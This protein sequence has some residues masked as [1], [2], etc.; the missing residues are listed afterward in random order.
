[1]AATTPHQTTA[2]EVSHAR[3]GKRSQGVATALA[4]FRELSVF[5][6]TRK[7]LANALGWDEKTVDRWARGDVSRVRRSGTNRVRGLLMLCTE[8]R[9]YM[10]RACDVGAWVL[11]RLPDWDGATPAA[12]VQER[13][14]RGVL[15]LSKRIVES[16]PRQE[17]KPL[18]E[19]SEEQIAEQRAVA[20]KRNPELAAFFIA[21]DELSI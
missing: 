10:E 11:T 15:Q 2:S 14:E 8:V 9:P 7:A 13:G 21:A 16:V 5:F 19:I 20:A 18:A 4:A 17:P 6:E 12:I 1:M 3:K